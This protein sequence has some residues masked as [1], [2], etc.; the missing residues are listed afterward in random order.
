MFYTYVIRSLKTGVLYKG[1]CQDLEKRMIQHNS[2]LTQ[3]IRHLIPLEM[4]YFEEFKTCEEAVKRERYF[5][6]AAGRR[7]LKSKIGPVV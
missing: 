2:G 1:H 6:T 5:K 4:I 3:S 7:F